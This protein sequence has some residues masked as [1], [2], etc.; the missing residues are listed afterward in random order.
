VDKSYDSNAFPDFLKDQAIKPAIAGK[1]NRTKPIQHDR[2]AY[3]KI[4][5]LLRAA[6][7][8]NGFQTH[9]DALRQVDQEFL[10]AVYFVA[11]LAFWR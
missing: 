2:P 6:F 9:S 5:T 1:S 3:K 7:V 4:A 10:S 8:G 11:T